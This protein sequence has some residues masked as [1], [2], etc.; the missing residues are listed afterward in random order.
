MWSIEKKRKIADALVRMSQRSDSQADSYTLESFYDNHLTDSLMNENN[1]ILQGSRGTGKTHILRVLKRK[2]ENEHT[3]CIYIDCRVLGTNVLAENFKES[4]RLNRF[5]QSFLNKFFEEL[6]KFY[7]DQLDEYKKHL[8][9]QIQSLLSKMKQSITIYTE[10][11]DTIEKISRVGE[12]GSKSST[13]SQNISLPF[14]TGLSREREKTEEQKF[15]VEVKYNS[16]IRYPTSFY[17]F[18]HLLDDLLQ[19]T[20]QKIILLIDEWSSTHPCIQPLFAEFIK[21]TL[22]P[23]SNVRFKIATT[24]QQK[25]FRCMIEANYYIGFEIGSDVQLALDLDS[26][27]S[28]DADP[29]E[30]ISFCFR[31]LCKHLSVLLACIIEPNEYIRNMFDGQKSAFMLV[32]AAE[33]NPRDFINLSFMCVQSLSD[34]D[35][36]IC[37]DKIL[38]QSEQLFKTSKLGNCNELA[39]KLMNE[40]INYVVYVHENRGFLIDSQYLASPTLKSLIDARALHILK[41]RY[42]GYHAINGGSAIIILDFGAYCEALNCGLCINFFSSGDFMENEIFPEKSYGPVSLQNVLQYDKN[43]SFYKCYINIKKDQRFF[44]YFLDV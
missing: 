22:F 38:F 28:V 15:A 32:R 20:N 31:F 24:P 37:E 14:K 18:S 43:R 2:L 33:G 42:M 4:T 9:E 35:I 17:Q 8:A 13:T 34:S 19:L 29:E 27:Y 39:Q 21:K 41:D 44:P 23:V 6:S 36:L 5:C 10:E 16:H 7:S 11:I 12:N 25:Q 30:L 26:K 40:L 1:Q 3:H